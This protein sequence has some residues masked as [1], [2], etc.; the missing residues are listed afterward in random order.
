MQILGDENNEMLEK[1]ADC[2]D[3]YT[4]VICEQAFFEGFCLGTKIVTESMT[5]A[6]EI[7]Q[8]DCYL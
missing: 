2:I 7:I 5:G 3:E 6:Q 4:E 8:R 1:Y